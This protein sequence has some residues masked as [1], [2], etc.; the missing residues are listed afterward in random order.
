MAPASAMEAGSPPRKQTTVGLPLCPTCSSTPSTMVGAGG[1]ETRSK[2]RVS[3]S[4]CSALMPSSIMMPPTASVTSRPPVPMPWLMPTPS[5]A[6]RVL[7]SWRPVPAAA[8][9]PTGPRGTALANPRATPLMMAVPQS[10]P[11]IS[12]PCFA[13]YFFRAISSSMGTLSLK[14]RT[15]N[16]LRSASHASAAAYC[17]A[18]EM[19]ARLMSGFVRTAPRI[20]R[21]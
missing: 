5:L 17:P 2:T 9:I 3:A 18:T 15:C 20:V 11:I 10:A 4:A 8:T 19:T 16:P 7:T 13:A 12:R 6:R 1:L 14:S 21:G